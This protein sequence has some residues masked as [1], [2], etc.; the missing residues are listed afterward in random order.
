MRMGFESLVVAAHAMGRTLVMPPHDDIYLLSSKFKEEEES[1]AKDEMGFLDFYDFHILKTQKG[2]HMMKMSKFLKK[3]GL[4][5]RLK[6]VLP[7]DNNVNLWGR[8]LWD[9]LS[10]VADT[11]P[12]WFDKVLAFPASPHDFELKNVTEELHNER[13]ARFRLQYDNMVRDVIYYDDV[14]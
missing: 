1:S 8:E 4:S 9:Y 12:K 2:F 5:G 6:G 11:T 13:L 14:S 7:P 3:E 10:K